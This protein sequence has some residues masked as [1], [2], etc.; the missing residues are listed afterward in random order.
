MNDWLNDRLNDSMNECMTDWLD[1]NAWLTK[2]VAGGVNEWTNEWLT[3]WLN[4]CLADC[5]IEWL[6]EWINAWKMSKWLNKWLND[7]PTAWINE[8][9]QNKLMSIL[10]FL[11]W[12]EF[13]QSVFHKPFHISHLTQPRFYI[14]EHY[15]N[16]L[17]ETVAMEPRMRIRTFA[18]SI[19]QTT[20]SYDSSIL[21]YT[22]Y[23]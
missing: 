17:K 8:C 4:D 9:H 5:M 1:E 14:P 10:L 18:L 21:K 19:N 6:N 15:R 13:F 20:L 22:F 11:S 16:R 7:W 23:F 12:I 3:E 2:W